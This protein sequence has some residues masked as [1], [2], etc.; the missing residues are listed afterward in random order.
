MREVK[1]DVLQTH[2]HAFAGER[3]WQI[4]ALIHGHGIDGNGGGVHGHLMSAVG[5]DTSDTTVSGQ[6]R[7]HIE[8]YLR[9]A[10]IIHLGKDTGTIGTEDGIAVALNTDKGG[11]VLLR[12]TRRWCTHGISPT[13][14]GG[15]LLPH[16]LP[17]PTRHLVECGLRGLCTD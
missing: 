1:T 3:L 10:D 5:L 6:S 8:R 4:L 12:M 14:T 13:L 11:E 2:D 16:N 7:Q 17:H 15:Y 9:D